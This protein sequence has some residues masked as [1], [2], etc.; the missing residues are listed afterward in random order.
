MWRSVIFSKFTEINTPSQVF[1]SLNKVN[2]PE[3]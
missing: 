3:L 1:L 2:G